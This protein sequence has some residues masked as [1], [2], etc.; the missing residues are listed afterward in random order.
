MNPESPSHVRYEPRDANTRVVALAV[1]GGL[2]A[3]LVII[4]ALAELFH[5]FRAQEDAEDVLPSPMMTPELNQPPEPRLQVD[6]ASNLQLSRDA[7]QK[8]LKGYA[9]IDRKAEVVRIPIQAAMDRIIEHGLPDWSAS[10]KKSDG[11]T[12]NE[13]EHKK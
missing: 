9:W 3:L 10:K 1:A 12:Q 11:E 13:A 4:F 6:L 8:R 2:V 7:E 5:V